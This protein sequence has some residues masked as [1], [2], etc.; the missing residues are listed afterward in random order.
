MFGR[1]D[2]TIA[3]EGASAHAMVLQPALP[4][5]V[6]AKAPGRTSL[7]QLE[8]INEL[9]TPAALMAPRRE[10]TV[11]NLTDDDAGD[12]DISP[13]AIAIS[14]TGPVGPTSH[15]PLTRVHEI[16]AHTSWQIQRMQQRR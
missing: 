2:F 14:S 3:S 7:P 16:S 4:P 15:T 5:A 9:P 6:R 8:D 1:D 12:P 10:P 13:P 11:V